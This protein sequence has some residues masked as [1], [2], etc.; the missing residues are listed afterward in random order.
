MPC[1]TVLLSSRLS[2]ASWCWPARFWSFLWK[3]FFSPRKKSA[4]NCAGPQESHTGEDCNL[5]TLH[6]SSRLHHQKSVVLPF[7][8]ENNFRETVFLKILGSRPL[9]RVEYIWF[10][11]VRCI[12]AKC[13]HALLYLFYFNGSKI[14]CTNK[15][16][17]R[18]CTLFRRALSTF[19]AWI[20]LATM[21]INPYRG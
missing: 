14:L 2:Q 19:L 17:P 15:N 12:L 21:I 4:N 13:Y 8:T 18:K 11:E 20:K 10:V 16:L 3:D 6:V 1:L 9:K 5:I 7:Q